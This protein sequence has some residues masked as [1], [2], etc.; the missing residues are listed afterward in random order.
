MA[1]CRLRLLAIALMA[2]V[3]LASVP[4]M[5]SGA[6]DEVNPPG[7]TILDGEIWDKLPFGTRSHWLQPW[8]AYAETRPTSVFLDGLGLVLNITDE[9]PDLVFDMAARIGFRHARIEIGWGDFRADDE[10]RPKEVERL[11]RLLRSTK[12]WGLRPLLLLNAHHAGPVPLVRRSVVV[13]APAPAGARSVHLDDTTG[14]I[15]GRSGLSDL[16]EPWAAEA[17][18][19]GMRGDRIELSRP[20]PRAI[21]AGARVALATLS[22]PP[23][24]A[25]YTPGY[26]VTLDGWLHYVD[27]VARF[28]MRAMGTKQDRDLG[29][30]LEIWNELAFGSNF[31]SVANYRSGKASPEDYDRLGKALVHDTAEHV[32]SHPDRFRG[33]Q[34]TDGF[35]STTPWPASSDEPARV[36]AI[37]KH[38]YPPHQEFGP[39]LHAHQAALD[40]SGRSA[41]FEPSYRVTFPE[42]AATALQTES[43]IRDLGPITND[44]YGAKHGRFARSVDGRVSPVAVW[45]TETGIAPEEEGFT[46]A[47]S[48]DTVKRKAILRQ[49]VFFLNKGADRVYFYAVRGPATGFGL[50]SQ[51]F[52]K[53]TRTSTTYPE[54][55][56]PYL[57]P[58]LRALQ[59]LVRHFAIGAERGFR[60]TRPIQATEVTSERQQLVFHGNGTAGEP[61][62][63]FADVFTFLPF[64]SN[65]HRFVIPFYVMTRQLSATADCGFYHLRVLGIQPRNAQFAIYDPVDD[66]ES[67]TVAE[68]DGSGSAKLRLEACDYPRL[69]LVE[70][71]G[72]DGAAR[73]SE[74]R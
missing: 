52:L 64:Q 10:T 39:G 15:I 58:A 74:S 68:D 41:D 59:E 24:D 50:F 27:N 19:T 38:P 67:E 70:E 63:R 1:L 23:F 60:A 69:L 42:Y 54:D 16:T 71:S 47:R 12:R 55:G 17:L 33:V 73:R 51:D 5:S 7:L 37:S 31:L 35:A 22:Y 57:T 61:D 3:A 8:Q 21:S 53:R 11:T 36:A 28:A 2:T 13:T 66:R 56:S 29:F 14:L 4:R 46:E 32:V 65:A 26:R 45:I 40:A 72:K 25:P 6:E 9:N 20:L 43:V 18:V 49:A 34:L 48:A 30:D 44:I 62:Q